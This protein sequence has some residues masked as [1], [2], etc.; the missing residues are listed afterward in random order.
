MAKRNPSPSAPS[1]FATGTRQSAKVTVLVGWLFQP[2][3]RSGAPKDRPGVDFS[4]TTQEMP[5]GASSPVRSI[6]D[7]EIGNAAAGDERLGAVYPVLGIAL[8]HRAGFQRRGVR[9]RARFGE[10]VADELVGGDDAG[11]E[12]GALLRIAEAGDHPGDHVVDAQEGR[13][14][15]V[16]RGQ[17][18]E[19]QGG[20]EPGEAG[21][22]MGLVHID[23]GK[24]EGG[25]RAQFVGGEMALLVPARGMRQPFLAGEVAGGLLERKLVRR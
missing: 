24:A 4:T 22:A 17:F 19:D 2:S 10:A 7:V 1:R 18:L 13:G 9:A 8:R 23:G 3:L 21:A 15:G 11:Q 20:I 12:A 5:R 14:G 6:V 25:G 16:G